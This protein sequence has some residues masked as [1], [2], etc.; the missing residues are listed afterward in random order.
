MS[1]PYGDMNMSDR[2]DIV[3][4]LIL[5]A[6]QKTGYMSEGA[7][8]REFTQPVQ[9]PVQCTVGPGLEGAI[10]CES[11]VGYVSGS[12]GRLVYRGYDIFDLCAYSTFEEVSY[13]LVHGVMPS[14]S[15]L[16]E[17]TGLLKQYRHIPHTLR[18]MMGFP[19]EK[20]NTMAALR[21]GTT[22][23]RHEFTEVDRV[24]DQKVAK[25]LIAADE[26]SIPMETPPMG[27][28]HAIYE[29]KRDAR[30]KKRKVERAAQSAIGLESCYHLIS[31]VASITAAIGRLRRGLMPLEPDNK[32]GHAANLLYMI[33]GQRPTPLQERLMD[34]SLILHADHGMNASTFASLVVASTL[35]DMYLSVGAGIAA[36]NGPLHGGANQEV[37]RMLEDIGHWR[38]VPAWYEK[39]R[40]Q[41]RKVMGFGH[42]VYKTY[43]PRARI[44]GP[45]AGHLAK[46]DEKARRLLRT[47]EALEKAV[48]STLGIK[49]GIYPNVDLYSGIVYGCMGIPVDLFTP[50][51]AVSRVS[52]W[53]ARLVEYLRNN[54][55][56]RP[57]AIYNGP[58][59][60]RYVP[61]GSR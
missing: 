13:L 49:K 16:E 3:T 32:L 55:I 53:T 42:R 1:V 7:T 41:K 56:F 52:G 17:Y 48:V 39:T 30:K 44:L 18:L 29:F 12:T 36:L 22:L 51:F 20:M 38:N 37:L 9:W 2:N 21:L 23:M 50:I 47:A 34:V 25:A 58:F 33:T 8:E 19:V 43:D 27:E 60:L 26:D 10:A 15:Q 14:R 4:R 5:D 57:R 35:S 31:G 11:Q 45:L 59:G 6:A 40:A 46:E 28:K 24:P 61:I 54:R